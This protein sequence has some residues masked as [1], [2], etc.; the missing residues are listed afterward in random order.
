MSFL[1]LSTDL[2]TQAYPDQPLA[3]S[4][5]ATVGEVVEL[6]RAQRGSCVLV[7]S[8]STDGCKGQVDG[9]FTERDA[10]RWMAAGQSPDLNIRKAMTARP[11]MLEANATVGQAI[12]LM[13]EGGYRHLPIVDEQRSPLGVA[14]VGGI[15]HYLVDHFPQTIY[16]LP[17][18]PGKS[19]SDREGA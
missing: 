1:S 11:T 2:V 6:M 18:E 10:L 16:T 19:P 8:E 4:G 13:S 15:V 3:V 7:C 14:A 17:P 9:I 12:E 5:D